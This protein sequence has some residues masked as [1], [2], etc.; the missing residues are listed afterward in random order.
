MLVVEVVLVCVHP[1]QLVDAATHSRVLN[2]STITLKGG[3]LYLLRV[4][5]PTC[6]SLESAAGVPLK[7]LSECTKNDKCVDI[8]YYMATGEGECKLSSL[9]E[10]M[11]QTD[12]RCTVG[13][14]L[15]LQASSCFG[16]TAEMS[17]RVMSHSEMDS[18]AWYTQ[19]DAAAWSA[20]SP[21]MIENVVA[22]QMNSTTSLFDQSSLVWVFVLVTDN[23]HAARVQMT[24]TGPWVQQKRIAGADAA[25]WCCFEMRRVLAVKDGVAFFAL[26]DLSPRRQWRVRPA[27]AVGGGGCVTAGNRADVQTHLIALSPHPDEKQQDR[28]EEKEITLESL[29]VA[30]NAAVDVLR[31]LAAMWSEARGSDSALALMVD[32]LRGDGKVLF[33][34]GG[35]LREGTLCKTARVLVLAISYTMPA[36]LC[37]LVILLHK[38]L[39][40]A[41]LLVGGTEF[42]VRE[43]CRMT[44][45][46]RCPKS[47]TRMR[48]CVFE[49]MTSKY[50]RYLVSARKV[51]L[52]KGVATVDPLFCARL[53]AE[54]YA[55]VWEAAASSKRVRQFWETVQQRIP[56]F[57]RC[58]R[59]SVEAILA[60]T[61]T[62]NAGGGVYAEDGREKV[63]LDVYLNTRA[64]VCVKQFFCPEKPIALG[65]TKRTMLLYNLLAHVEL[66]S[67]QEGMKM[68][69]LYKWKDT[70][71]LQEQEREW[72]SFVKDSTRLVAP[73]RNKADFFKEKGMCSGLCNGDDC[74]YQP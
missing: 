28:G 30:I 39:A 2:F 57:Y 52:C 68:G 1:V 37:K 26:S 27:M 66:E 54:R 4:H 8:G 35:K 7:R 32:W 62:K 69:L 56:F 44:G 73:P 34:V 13:R 72:E 59:T 36:G 9:T 45:A 18:D 22:V 24:S 55:D 33:G 19:V 6:D 42:I 16:V 67:L 5:S 10:E 17:V 31:Q 64:G 21:A 3:T 43:M 61:T 58:T 46:T 50:G 23:P 38:T 25:G 71:S 60:K 15:R 40:N 20:Q 11:L 49:L 29:E 47:S 65:N 48:V 51:Q 53:V 41:C 12:T 63:K 74:L 70:K 14:A